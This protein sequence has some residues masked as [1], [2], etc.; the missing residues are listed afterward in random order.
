MSRTL[1]AARSRR[2]SMAR[3]ID[4]AGERRRMV[5]RLVRS[6][7]VREPAVRDAFLSVP[8]EAFVQAADAADA[9][10]DVPLPI[11]RGQ[12]ISAP[13]MIA[14][15][16]EEARLRSGER[17]LEIGTG[18]GY[19]AALLA[20]LVGAA[21][22]VTIERHAELAAQGRANL[23]RV[24]AAEVTVVVGDGSLGFSERAP[25]DCILATAGAPHIPE[26]WPTQLAPRGRIVAPIGPS[27]QGQVLV[28]A[29]RRADGSL[30]V[31]ETTPCAF[32][33]LIGAQAWP[34]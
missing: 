15:M 10:A 19:G 29:M 33:P 2:R 18:A 26:A 16:L 30:N 27:R 34:E 12:T 28:V 24:R 17:V 5:D 25:Y 7:Y 31:R 1:M 6:H 9:Y 23:A 8:R 21:N 3:E 14:I 32:V 13:S 11:G 4:F 22:V 20:H